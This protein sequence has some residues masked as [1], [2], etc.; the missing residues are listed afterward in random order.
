[1][2]KH[3][4]IIIITIAAI[5]LILIVLL[6]LFYPFNKAGNG[7]L[8]INNTENTAS[9]SEIAVGANLP[10]IDT[11]GKDIMST[12][13]LESLGLYHRAVYEVLER[14][15]SGKVIKTQ[16]IGIKKA[17]SLASEI[18]TIEEKTT[19]NIAST[20]KIQI[21]KRDSKGNIV[22]YRVMKDDNDIIKNY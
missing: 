21:L 20:T 7:T 8:P 3:T 9:S 6:L 19:F 2:N 12:E 15:K 22:S 13:E 10:P 18:M 17:E 5:S 1:M 14:D 16:L 4:K 11:A